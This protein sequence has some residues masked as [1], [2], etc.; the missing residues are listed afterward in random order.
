MRNSFNVTF[1]VF[2]FLILGLATTLEV[3]AQGRTSE[4]RE[5]VDIDV[6][7]DKGV[8]KYTVSSPGVGPIGTPMAKPKDQDVLFKIF[9][10]GF[11]RF[12]ATGSVAHVR[13]GNDPGREKRGYANRGTA[14]LH[15]GRTETIRVRAPLDSAEVARRDGIRNTRHQILIDCCTGG[16]SRQGQCIDPVEGF[17]TA[18][19]E[20]GRDVNLAAGAMTPQE[21]ARLL[22]TQQ[23]DDESPFPVAGPDMDVQP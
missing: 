18:L 9:A 8:C 5:V 11:L 10:H 4:R 19:N 7:L 6:T 1:S 21:L 20:D 2:L 13:I 12:T 14:K 3:A 22:A 16:I 23:S 15:P 17:A